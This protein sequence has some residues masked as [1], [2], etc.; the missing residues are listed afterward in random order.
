MPSLLDEKLNSLLVDTFRSIL[1][2]EEKSIKS[3]GV[4]D[5]SIN[6][7]HMIEAVGKQ[8]HS[9]ASISGI[10]Q[11]LGFTPPSV[12]IAVNKLAQKGYV[13][14]L[15]GQSDGRVVIVQLTRKGVRMDRAH[16]YFHQQMIKHIGLLLSDDEKEIFSR[17]VSRLDDFLKQKIAELEV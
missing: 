5:L 12:T 6:E 9:G 7:L 15:R 10:A 1:K 3:M 13:E 2:V 11:E 17:G 4:A 8:G 14:K 16:K